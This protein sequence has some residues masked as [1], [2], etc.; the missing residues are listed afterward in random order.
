MMARR[1]CAAAVLCLALVLGVALGSGQAYGFP[2][3]PPGYWAYAWI[4]W[5]AANG[6]VQ[7]YWDGYHPEEPMTRAQ[8]A[9]FITRT[10]QYLRNGRGLGWMMPGSEA[11]ECDIGVMGDLNAAEYKLYSS[12]DGVTFG[13]VTGITPDVDPDFGLVWWHLTN[14]VTDIYFKPMEVVNTPTGPMERKLCGLL[15]A[16]PGEPPDDIVLDSP[17]A[18][19]DVPR[20]PSIL[21]EPV[22]RAVFYLVAVLP[23]SMEGEPIYAAITEGYR[24]SVLYGNDF[25]PG[26]LGGFCYAEA[27]DAGT[28][29]AL[30]V[31]GLDAGGWPVGMLAF[32]FTTAS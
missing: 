18:P 10:M 25:G 4:E 3:V 15:L 11:G 30:I 6:I 16:R 20:V 2:D 8:M 12:L 26:I 9:V 24:T 31:E 5:L 29:Y 7:G 14:V 17:S 32:S 23:A 1:W 28:S 21:W 27:L 22:P 19:T 13:E